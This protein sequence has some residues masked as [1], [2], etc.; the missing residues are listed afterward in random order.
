[1]IGEKTDD[2]MNVNFTEALVFTLQGSH[3]FLIFV[4]HH[5]NKECEN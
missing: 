5:V 1:M 2:S 3:I 4:N